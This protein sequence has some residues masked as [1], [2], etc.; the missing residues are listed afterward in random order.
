MQSFEVIQEIELFLKKI[1]SVEKE[2]EFTNNEKIIQAGF[3]L[4]DSFRK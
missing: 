3:D 1:Q 2:V 4:K